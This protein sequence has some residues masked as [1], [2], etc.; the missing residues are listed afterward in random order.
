MEKKEKG[1]E[2]TGCLRRRFSSKIHLGR[3]ALGR[4][5]SEKKNRN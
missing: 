2:G 1:R 3:E 4:I 5:E